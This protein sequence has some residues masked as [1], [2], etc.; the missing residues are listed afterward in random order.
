MLYPPFGDLYRYSLD[1][2]LYKD[3]NFSYFLLYAFVEYDYLLSF[4][5]YGLGNCGLPCDLSRFIF[6]FWGFY[7]YGML[8]YHITTDNSIINKGKT[9]LKWFSVYFFAISFCGFCFRFSLAMILFV[10]GSYFIVYKKRKKYWIFVLLSVLCHFSFVLFAIS[11]SVSRIVTFAPK[12]NIWYFLSACGLL[13]GI[14]N[15]GVFL[16]LKIIGGNLVD[17]YDGYFDK[18]D[19]GQYAENFSWKALIWQKFG[20]LWQFLFYCYYMVYRHLGSKRELSLPNIMTCI[21]LA[22]SPFSV[23]FGRFM[24]VALE[25]WRLFYMEHFLNIGK[26]KKQLNILLIFAILSF[27]LQFWGKRRELSVSDM[28]LLFTSTSVQILDHQYTP[29]WVY[30]NVRAD[31]GVQK[32]DD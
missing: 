12:R 19:M 9:G 11:L 3:L 22:C 14:F 2:D 32:Y 30:K 20:L 4:L 21:C 6:N 26:M 24:T 18:N 16:D 13:F 31:G 5:L 7:L 15:T 25:F 27:V 17:R 29:S 1:Y 23:V 10:Y 28:H 8:Y